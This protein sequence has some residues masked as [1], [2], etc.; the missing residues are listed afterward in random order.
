MANTTR[1]NKLKAFPLTGGED[2]V[3]APIVIPDGTAR[4][5][6]NYQEG[7][8]T[9]YTRINGY[10][11]LVN[12]TLPGEGPVRGLVI[13]NNK[14]YLFQDKVGG[15]TGGMWYAVPATYRIGSESAG[16]ETYL[17]GTNIVLTDGSWVEVV[18]ITA[19]RPD[20]LVATPGAATTLLPGGY[21]E[22]VESNFSATA[23]TIDA[24]DGSHDISTGVGKLYGVDGVNPA[25]EFHDTVNQIVQLDSTY[26]NDSPHHIAAQGN[27]LL[28]GFRAGEV[29]ISDSLGNPHDFNPIR[30][31]GSVGVQDLLTALLPGPDGTVYVF[32]KDN[33]YILSDVQGSL[34]S[35]VLKRYSRDTGAYPYTTASMAGKVLFYD[36]W[37]VTEL[38]QTEYFGSVEATSYSQKVQEA[39]KEFQPVISVV[40]KKD[41]QYRTYFKNENNAYQTVLL[42][43][44]MIKKMDETMGVSLSHSV[45]PF[46]IHHAAL[47]EYRDPTVAWNYQSVGE[48]H[49]AGVS[50]LVEDVETYQVYQMDV[51]NSFNGEPYLSYMTLPFNFLASPSKVKKFRKMVL[52]T[53]TTS[54]VDIQ[55][56]INFSF[57][58]LETPKDTGSVLLP[59]ANSKWYEAIWDNFYWGGGQLDYLDGYI[60]GFGENIE[61]TI[62]SNS[63]KQAPHTLKDIS[64]IYQFQRIEH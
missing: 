20:P 42:N 35:A 19:A 3:T 63:A 21:Y 44:S 25:F 7:Y 53:D 16:D 40:S 52:N 60:N 6:Y 15:V 23:Y 47:S 37:G 13:Y 32:C 28:L 1:Q 17:W 14:H 27:R 46:E 4:V 57:G 39:Y 29:A 31:A 49:I 54:E 43:T 11:K 48:Q 2:L 38:E 8:N 18:T 61:V 24:V 62:I 58:A 34:D 50:E 30:G 56:S 51:G 45:Y 22:F 64:F 41:A 5:L 26:D 36:T 12:G 9:G 33:V 10:R 55:Y 59:P